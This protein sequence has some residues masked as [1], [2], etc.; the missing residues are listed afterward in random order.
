MIPRDPAEQKRHLERIHASVLTVMLSRVGTIADAL[1]EKNVGS[2]RIENLGILAIEQGRKAA[3]TYMASRPT[4]SE[5]DDWDRRQWEAVDE[6]EQV[7]SM[8]INHIIAL[9]DG[10]EQEEEA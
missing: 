5:T 3:P 1:A 4:L 10:T 9:R 6:A 2:E 7:F 8:F